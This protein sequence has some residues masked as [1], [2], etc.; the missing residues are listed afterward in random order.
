MAVT[1]NECKDFIAAEGQYV[2]KREIYLEPTTPNLTGG[3]LISLVSVKYKE[4]TSHR[5][6]SSGDGTSTEPAGDNNTLSN[7]PPSTDDSPLDNPAEDAADSVRSQPQLQNSQE[8]PSPTTTTYKEPVSPGD[9]SAIKSP[10]QNSFT[11]KQPLGGNVPIP[12][13]I[14]GKRDDEGAFTSLFSAAKRKKQP[15]HS[16]TKTNSSFVTKIITN[17]NFAKILANRQNEDTYLF[18]NIGRTFC[19][20]DLTNNSKVT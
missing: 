13:A 10:T 5:Q 18:Y 9:A 17:E 14:E 20:T 16:I 11:S 1:G 19:W 6:S 2:L 15:K 3:T 12:T 7:R 8:P 4:Y